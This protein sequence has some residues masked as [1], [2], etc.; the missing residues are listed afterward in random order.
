M[1]KLFEI[2]NK[3]KAIRKDETNPF[4]NSSYFDI[5]GLLEEL[6]PILNDAGVIVIQPL[7]TVEGKTALKTLVMDSELGTALAES[8]VVLPENNDPQKMGSIITYFRRYALQSLFLLQAVDDDANMASRQEEKV[9]ARSPEPPKVKDGAKG[10]CP[11]C[12]APMVMSKMGKIY[13]S[14]KCWLKPSNDM[15]F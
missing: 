14:A 2:Q 11:K 12:H 7:T 5:N 10:D 13:C 3:I 15:P 4:Y 6:K 9:I 1:N 8:V